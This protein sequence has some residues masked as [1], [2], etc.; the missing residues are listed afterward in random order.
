MS[1]PAVK[2]KAMIQDNTRCIGC[3]A[4]MV[5]CKSWNDL[6]ADKTDF[7]AGEGYQNPRDLDANNYT[8]ITFNEIVN[9]PHSR[10]GI[11]APAVHALRAARLRLGVPDYRDV[12]NGSRP[13]RVRRVALHRL[14]RV[15]AGMPI[16]HSE[17]RLRELRAEDPQ[18]HV[19]RRPSGGGYGPGVRDRMPDRRHQFRRP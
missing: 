12:Q 16:H 4:C 19:L 7:F 6:P 14:S 5:A 3:R 1:T 8:L 15:H 9:Q 17:I 18:M 13:R 10:L 11:R 2:P